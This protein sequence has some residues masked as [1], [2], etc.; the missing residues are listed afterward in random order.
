MKDGGSAFPT[1][2]SNY[3]ASYCDSGMSVR[4]VYAALAMHALIV[5]TG[6]SQ[7]K[8]ADRAFKMADVMLDREANG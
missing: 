5:A 3:T 7:E 1:T 6:V 4:Q 2:A 8:I